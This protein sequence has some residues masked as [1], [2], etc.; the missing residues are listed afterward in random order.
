[1]A[2]VAPLF[3]MKIIKIGNIEIEL[4]FKMKAHEKYYAK[5]GKQLSDVDL[6]NIIGEIPKLI[7]AGQNTNYT[8]DEIVNMLDDSNM[9][10]TDMVN[11]YHDPINRAFYLSYL[12]KEVIEASDEDKE[13]KN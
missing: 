5:F 2:R 4:K 6:N 7:Y 10:I 8:Y 3:V 9:T 13:E 11:T 1:M 12:G